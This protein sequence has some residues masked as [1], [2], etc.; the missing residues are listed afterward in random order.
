[1]IVEIVK[2]D[3]GQIHKG[4]LFSSK[5]EEMIHKV[6]PD[7]ISSKEFIIKTCMDLVSKMSYWYALE[8]GKSFSQMMKIG[9]LAV[10][11]AVERLNNSKRIDFVN[12]ISQEI[13]KAMIEG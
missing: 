8:N 6:A 2:P 1:M 3:I 9:E 7:Y 5:Q 13:L 11:N 10:I 12:F 4:V